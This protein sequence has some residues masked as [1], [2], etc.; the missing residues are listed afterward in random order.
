MYCDG[1]IFYESDVISLNNIFAFN[2]YFFIFITG[3]HTVTHHHTTQGA[4]H[5]QCIWAGGTHPHQ[6]PPHNSLKGTPKDTH[7]LVTM[8]IL[9]NGPIPGW[10][11]NLVIPRGGVSSLPWVNL[12][13]IK[14]RY[15]LNR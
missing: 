12:V 14:N 11:A 13:S 3:I 2:V 4:C 1:Q 7:P 5:P 8:D 6:E 15:Y 10:K 9:N